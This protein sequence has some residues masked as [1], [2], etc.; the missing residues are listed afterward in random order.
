MK[1]KLI[2]LS[3]LLLLSVFSFAQHKRIHDGAIIYLIDG[4]KL[5]GE[6][7]ENNKSDLKLKLISGDVVTLL[8]KHRRKTYL[9]EEIVLFNGSKF[10]YQ[11]GFFF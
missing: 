10:H 11:K 1:H 7:V 8:P 2:S 5:V 9:P 6:L 4:S 3:V